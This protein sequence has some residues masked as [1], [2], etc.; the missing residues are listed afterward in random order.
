MNDINMLPAARATLDVNTDFVTL[1]LDAR[2]AGVV[3]L[4][5]TWG[6]TAEYGPGCV[7]VHLKTLTGSLWSSHRITADTTFNLPPRTE[8]VE[9]LVTLRAPGM[10]LELTVTQSAELAPPR[11]RRRPP[12]GR[13]PLIAG[14]WYT[15]EEV[16]ARERRFEAYRAAAHNRPQEKTN[17]DRRRTG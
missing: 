17:G 11:T 13:H 12:I 3:S 5:G 15:P 7:V 14:R 4:S 8:R 10:D 16:A 2:R 9:A 1:P 6:D